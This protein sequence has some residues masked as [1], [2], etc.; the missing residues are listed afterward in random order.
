MR[1][2][3][4]HTDLRQNAVFHNF[5]RQIAPIQYSEPYEA[6]VGFSKTVQKISKITYTA[7]RFS[8]LTSAKFSVNIKRGTLQHNKEFTVFIIFYLMVFNDV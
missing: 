5:S 6:R 2:C 3:F 4:Y 7:R 8:L 1:R